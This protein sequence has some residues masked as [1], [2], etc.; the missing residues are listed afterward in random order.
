M[1][2]F[3]NPRS[4]VRSTPGL[5]TPDG[6]ISFRMTHALCYARLR[7]KKMID[8]GVTRRFGPRVAPRMSRTRQRV[9]W[10]FLKV[11]WNLYEVSTFLASWD[12]EP[13][14]GWHLHHPS[15]SEVLSR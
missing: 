6:A 2:G 1:A 5:V 9:T 11:S 10:S 12:P 8:L 13:Q 3:T 14:S 15:G 7:I 4:E